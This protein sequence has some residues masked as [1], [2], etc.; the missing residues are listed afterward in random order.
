MF[1]GIEV[2]MVAVTFFPA[3]E[4]APSPPLVGLEVEAVPPVLRGQYSHRKAYDE[5]FAP[6][7]DLSVFVA[8][9]MAADIGLS[10]SLPF[11]RTHA[12]AAL[13]RSN[14]VWLYL[15]GGLAFFA[16]DSESS[17]EESTLKAR[18]IMYGSKEQRTKRGRQKS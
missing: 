12:P 4:P 15:P 3:E 8:A 10:L 6:N 7:S 14:R 16:R 13:H 1:G 5:S 2:A 17:L 18:S 9:C 11:T